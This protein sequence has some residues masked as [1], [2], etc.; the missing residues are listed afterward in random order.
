[1]Q[2]VEY[3]GS[4]NLTNI[5]NDKKYDEGRPILQQDGALSHGLF[6]FTPP[7]RLHELQDIKLK[8]TQ[9]T[10]NAFQIKISVS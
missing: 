9:T 7:K 1:M 10:N 5:Y 8:L 6:L 3:V 4:P 2:I